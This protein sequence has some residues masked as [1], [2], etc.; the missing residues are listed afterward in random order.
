MRSRHG[1]CLEGKR[2]FGNELNRTALLAMLAL[3][4][5]PAPAG[6]LE[7]EHVESIGA[8]GIG[9][10]R[11]RYVEDFAFTR[12]G[13]LLVTDAAHAWVQVFDKSGNF[14]AR[15]GGPG[16]DVHQL[17]KPEGIAVEGRAALDA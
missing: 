11:F 5:A 15:F 8:E 3:L 16:D 4:P 1:V 6:P 12:D 14:L 10:G 7:F 13:R 2:M 17:E 9:E